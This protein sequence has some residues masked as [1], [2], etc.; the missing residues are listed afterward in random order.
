MCTFSLSLLLMMC[1]LF[2][3]VDVR[4]MFIRQSSNV[5]NTVAL[6]AFLVGLTLS[7]N[8]NSHIHWGH[9]D[10]WDFL[11]FF[12]SHSLTHSYPYSLYL[13]VADQWSLL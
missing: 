9:V 12:L 1:I 2:Y 5:Y 7:N 6:G 13:H 11:S 4:V 10:T 3:S 8:S